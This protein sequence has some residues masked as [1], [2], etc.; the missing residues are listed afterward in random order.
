[1]DVMNQRLTSTY[2]TLNE[3][4]PGNQLLRR[5]SALVTKVN[6]LARAVNAHSHSG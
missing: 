3:T 4:S 6:E 5:I 1:M 2:I